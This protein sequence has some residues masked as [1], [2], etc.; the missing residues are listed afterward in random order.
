MDELIYQFL[1]QAGF[2]R[3]AIVSDSTLL[4]SGTGA[5]PDDASTYVI[6][7]PETADRLAVVDVVGAID[8]DALE[9]AAGRAGRYARRIG[10]REIQGFVIRVDTRGR[11]EAEQVQFY[12]VWPNPDVQQLTAKTF[13]DLDALRVTGLLALER[14]TPSAPEIVDFGDE[15][16]AAEESP[17][18]RGAAGRYVP[19]IVLILLATVDWFVGQTRGTGLL[20]IVQALLAVG[21][22]SLL[23][24]VA[25]HRRR[26]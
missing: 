10:G 6:V 14:A 25:V 26:D 21:A 20:T 17:A 19:A 2:P 4:E 5:P 13:P 8:G 3:A 7:D 23:T 16:D 9:A 11:T 18:G 12:R 1:L 24:L 22:A 15:T